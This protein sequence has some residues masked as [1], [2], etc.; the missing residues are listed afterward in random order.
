MLR[1]SLH[2]ALVTVV[3]AAGL[4]LPAPAHGRPAAP[5]SEAATDPDALYEEGRKDFSQGFFKAAIEKFEAA[6]KR[7]KD[8]L[9]LYN[10]G[11]SYKKLHDEDPQL[12]YLR[13]A[14]TALQSYVAA[15][16]KDP[17]LGADPEE[18]KPLLAEIDAEL[19]R[20]EP[21]AQP[22]G[23]TEPTEPAVPRGEDPGKK[24]RLAGVG[25][26]GGGGALLVVGS[27]VGGVYA[28]KGGRLSEELNGD[29]GL[30]D[31]QEMMMGCPAMAMVGESNDCTSLRD[32]IDSTR[33]AGEKSNIAS[34]VSFGVVGGL[35]A[36]LLIGGA[37]AFS[38]GR[39]RTADW[40]SGTARV[41]VA[42]TFGGLVLQG[43]F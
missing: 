19:A 12:E 32:R 41:R 4:T 11:Q 26:M 10:I 20:R 36:L 15:V 28:A 43:R 38:L 3:A 1:S 39:K 31:Q 7:S 40:K 6:Y 16:E 22:E 2:L 8:P 34:A 5:K 37:V 25:L 18:V 35:G 9:I 30:Y 21:K 13:K 14:R 23:P 33:S 42:P 24:L 27:I 17:S 29:G